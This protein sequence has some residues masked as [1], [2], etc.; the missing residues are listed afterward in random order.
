MNNMTT[1]ELKLIAAKARK[2]CVEAVY[3]AS[4][5]HPGGSLSA[6]SAASML[7]YE[8]MRQNKK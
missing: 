1:K 2:L 6:A 7:G 5:G 4:S 8:V 3:T